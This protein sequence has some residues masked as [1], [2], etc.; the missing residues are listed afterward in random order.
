MRVSE[1]EGWKREVAGLLPIRKRFSPSG[2]I[3]IKPLE[4]E[5]G[6]YGLSAAL[7]DFER[8]AQYWSDHDDYMRRLDRGARAAAFSQP[9]LFYGTPRG[10]TPENELEDGI[11]F[12]FS[13]AL[14]LK[15]VGPEEELGVGIAFLLKSLNFTKQFDWPFRGIDTLDHVWT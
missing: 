5:V 11:N 13:S 7:R 6:L 9:D 2:W 1:Q 12:L 8:L 15:G 10:V 4:C 14:R 3:T